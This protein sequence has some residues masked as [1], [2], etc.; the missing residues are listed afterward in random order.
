MISIIIWSAWSISEIVYLQK[1]EKWCIQCGFY[2]YFIFSVRVYIFLFLDCLRILPVCVL[3]S[4]LVWGRFIQ[5]WWRFNC[6]KTGHVKLNGMPNQ[7]KPNEIQLHTP[8]FGN[9]NLEIWDLCVCVCVHTHKTPWKSIVT[10][11]DCRDTVADCMYSLVNVVCPSFAS[12][13]DRIDFCGCN[14]Y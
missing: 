14:S 8:H 7:T 10:V 5:I 11:R 6:S 4:V 12:T 1:R 3:H 2:L 9:R 13:I